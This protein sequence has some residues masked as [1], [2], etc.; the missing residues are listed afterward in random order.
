MLCRKYQFDTIKLKARKYLS[1]NCEDEGRLTLATPFNTSIKIKFRLGDI[2][3]V[4]DY[5]S[6]MS[7][8]SDKPADLPIRYKILLTKNIPIYSN[9]HHLP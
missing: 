8:S 4:N 7:N 6:K 1:R 5:K 2:G 3:E 9:Y